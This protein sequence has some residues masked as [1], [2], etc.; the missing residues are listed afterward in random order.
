VNCTANYTIVRSFC[1]GGIIHVVLR[2]PIFL[3]PIAYPMAVKDFA[4]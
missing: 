3:L 4:L 1:K 2:L